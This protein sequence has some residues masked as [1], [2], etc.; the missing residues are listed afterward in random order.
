MSYKHKDRNKIYWN[1]ASI[2][3]IRSSYRKHDMPVYIS[4]T[5]PFCIFSCS[6]DKSPQPF[7]YSLNKNFGIMFY[8]KSEKIGDVF[9]KRISLDGAI[10]VNV[11]IGICNDG[12][13][14]TYRV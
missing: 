10:R 11:I 5:T 7:K 13:K 1:Q 2:S 8:P 12:F 9:C 4:T 14:S 6:T 3:D